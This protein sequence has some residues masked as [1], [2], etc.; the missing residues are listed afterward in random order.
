MATK[1]ELMLETVIRGALDNAGKFFRQQ[2]LRKAKEGTMTDDF[3]SFFLLQYNRT[4]YQKLKDAYLSSSFSELKIAIALEIN[5]NLPE[6]K[7]GLP[8]ESTEQKID[9]QNDTSAV[10]SPALDETPTLKVENN[11]GPQL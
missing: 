4:D 1:G 3:C 11:L 8:I 9:Q 5:A 2:F 10:F 7:D 6:L